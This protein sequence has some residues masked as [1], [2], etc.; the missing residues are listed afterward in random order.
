MAFQSN[1][2]QPGDF[3][4]NSQADILGNFTALASFGAGYADLSIQATQPP[5]LA[6]GAV[7]DSVLYAFVNPTTA[8]GE[9]Y[10]QKQIN[11]GQA[12]I[13]MTASSMSTLAFIGCEIGWSYLP[14]GLLVKWGNVNM[15]TAT[16][17]ITPTVTSGGPNFQRAFQ[18]FLTAYDTSVNTNF[19]VGQR[20][21][22]SNALLNDPTTG[23]FTAYANNPSAT[24]EINYIVIGV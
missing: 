4:K 16:L 20:T 6:V 11:G 2:P 8:V 9:L 7:T 24:T 1:I 23:N 15:T 5:T 14:S 12:Q 18:V 13:P 21:T 3:L 22:V 19:T 10:V 17:A